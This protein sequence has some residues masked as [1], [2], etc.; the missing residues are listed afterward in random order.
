MSHF[1]ILYK[2]VNKVNNKFYIG[3]HKTVDIHD[4]YMGSGHLIKAAIAKYGIEN[5]TKE[6]INVFTNSVDAYNKEREIITKELLESKQC[7]N[8]KEGGRGGF[9][10][11][12]Q[13]NLHKW[14]KGKVIIHNPLTGQQTKVSTDLLQSYL[15]KGWLKGFKPEA[16]KRMSESGKIKIQTA[17]HRSKNSQTKKGCKKLIPPEHSMYKQRYKFIKIEKVEE[18]IAA[19]WRL[20]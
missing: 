9:E 18:Y 4:N 19:G 13:K 16:L 11:I 20:F 10:H 7:Y 5:F 12:R 8:I 14:S 15:D 6:I 1:Y 3:V 17:E 2:I